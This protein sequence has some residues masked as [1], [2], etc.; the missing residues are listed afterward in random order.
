MARMLDLEKE[1]KVAEE[2]WNFI[3]GEGAYEDLL[4]CFEHVDIE[5][6]E[7]IDNCFSKFNT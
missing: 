7:E 1:L 4:E 5:M 6:R 2:F 3:G